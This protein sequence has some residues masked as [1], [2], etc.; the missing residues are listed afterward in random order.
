MRYNIIHSNVR[1]SSDIQTPPSWLKNSGVASFFNSLL[2]VWISD[3]KLLVYNIL[4]LRSP[5]QHKVTSMY[6]WDWWEV[7]LFSLW[8]DGMKILPQECFCFF[9]NI[10]FIWGLVGPPEVESRRVD[11]RL[12][13][14]VKEQKW[15][16]FE[17]S[18][19]ILSAIR[20]GSCFRNCGLIVSHSVEPSWKSLQ[21]YNSHAKKE[22]WWWNCFNYR[23]STVNRITRSFN[24]AQTSHSS[25]RILCCNR[26]AASLHDVGCCNLVCKKENSD[27]HDRPSIH[28]L[29]FVC[30]PHHMRFNTCRVCGSG[31][32]YNPI[33][34]KYS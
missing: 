1:V 18:V 16:K 12:E 4:N 15:K 28:I 6:W 26:L 19:T 3:V 20:D 27:Y 21:I 10:L 7:D 8:S 30:Q 25:V 23:Y 22:D 13:E 17:G 2:G 11:W 32:N 29:E 9:L 34:T 33:A 14:G 31:F 5:V 24:F